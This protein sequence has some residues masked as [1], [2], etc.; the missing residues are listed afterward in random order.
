MLGKHLVAGALAVAVAGCGDIA[1]PAARSPHAP[2]LTVGPTVSVIVSCPSNLLDGQSGQCSAAGYDSNGQFT[3]STATWS[4]T[5][6]SVLGVSSSGVATAVHL[7]TGTG[8]VSATIGGVTGQTSITVTQSDLAISIG[9]PTSIRPNALCYWWANVTGGTAGY[10]YSWSQ[11]PGSATSTTSD[12]YAQGSSSFTVYL[13]VRDA[14][15]T[16][17]STSQPIT[18]SS[19]ARVCPT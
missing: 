17:R 1:S 11:S 15:G 14:L 12:F 19:S 5:T 3:G 6:S 13:T 2:R 10:T 8:N 4:T 9:G 16:W 18:V 7:A